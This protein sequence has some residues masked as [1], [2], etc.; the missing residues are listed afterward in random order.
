MRG[1]DASDS[2]RRGLPDVTE[3]T[4]FEKI[5]ETVLFRDETLGLRRDHLR[6][7][8]GAELH[9]KVVEYRKAA[10]ILAINGVGEVLLVR[11]YR[12]AVVRHLW[13]VPG[14]II[15][16]GERPEDAVARELLEET[17]LS[18][19]CL[20][21]LLS[22]YPEPAFTDHEITLFVG[23]E[24]TMSEADRMPED[25]IGELRFFSRDAARGLV[26]AGDVA[27]SWT[28]IALLATLPGLTSASGATS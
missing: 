7:P 10:A 25:E 18:V 12:H 8:S 24:L 13:D 22:F 15:E 4:S 28:L 17:G 9:R 20:T 5:G 21:R 1:V 23:R 3:T 2:D 6:A 16:P 14:G 26:E 19:G 11:H 27:S